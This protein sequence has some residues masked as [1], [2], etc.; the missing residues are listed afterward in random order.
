M[1][2]LSKT[3][4]KAIGDNTEQNQRVFEVLGLGS[5]KYLASSTGVRRATYA[6]LV[7]LTA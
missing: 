6:Q 2:G 3:F 5:T 4:E 7:G 1:K